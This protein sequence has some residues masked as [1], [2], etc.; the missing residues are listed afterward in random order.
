MSFQLTKLGLLFLETGQYFGIS[1]NRIEDK[2][3]ETEGVLFLKNRAAK[4]NCIFVYAN[5][6]FIGTPTSDVVEI[7]VLHK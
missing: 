4:E 3:S 6:I 5:Y 1:Q 7:E 2:Q